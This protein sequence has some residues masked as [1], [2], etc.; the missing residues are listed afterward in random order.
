M[1][2]TLADLTLLSEFQGTT[3]PEASAQSDLMSFFGPLL[4]HPSRVTFPWAPLRNA[5][6]A[7]FASSSPHGLDPQRIFSG[8]C[9]LSLILTAFKRLEVVESEADTAE[10]LAWLSAIKV[11]AV[12]RSLQHETFDGPNQGVLRSILANLHEPVPAESL[13]T[14]SRSRTTS[15]SYSKPIAST[16]TSF[17]R[18]SDATRSPPA[19]SQATSISPEPAPPRPRMETVLDRMGKRPSGVV[20]GASP[21]YAKRRRSNSIGQISVLP[22]RT[23][24]STVSTS[25]LSSFADFSDHQLDPLSSSDS[26]E[27]DE[28]PATSANASKINLLAQRLSEV[29]GIPLARCVETISR[30]P[31]EDLS[32][33]NPNAPIPAHF[34]P[35]NNATPAP[36]VKPEAPSR[37]TS[38]GS[39]YSYTNGNGKSAA[40]ATAKKATIE[41]AAKPLGRQQR[42]HDPNRPNFSYSAL[43]GQAILSTPEKRLRLADIYDYVTNNYSYYRKN[44]SGWQNSIRH[45]L[46][47]Q[48]VFQKIPDPATTSGTGKKGCL[49]T[50]IPS[51]EWRFEGGGWLKMDKPSAGAAKGKKRPSLAGKRGGSGLKGSGLKAEDE[52][53]EDRSVDQQEGQMADEEDGLFSEDDE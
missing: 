33:I 42:P 37:A 4:T 21:D 1:A 38:N 14:V 51:E 26:E 15:I 17:E 46:S 41:T 9:G 48:P 49:W 20:R 6:S 25:A 27:D 34:L 53:D 43:I 7:Y 18:G 2:A 44:E 32:A 19:S 50:I 36:P 29:T 13:V 35:Q 16:S 45:N 28:K 30:F 31:D 3:V 5:L 8:W 22:A 10:C 11:A 52:D 40:A 39:S 24:D 47:L 12:R 23:R